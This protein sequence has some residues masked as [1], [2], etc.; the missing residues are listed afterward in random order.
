GAQEISRRV[1]GRVIGT[2]Q[3][4]DI[5]GE[6]RLGA[7]EALFNSGKSEIYRGVEQPDRAARRTRAAHRRREGIY[8]LFRAARGMKPNLS[9][10]AS[11]DRNIPPALDPPRARL[12]H[13]RLPIPALRDPY[14]GAGDLLRGPHSL[15]AR[16]ARPRLKPSR[17]SVRFR[18]AY[19]PS[20]I[21]LSRE[22]F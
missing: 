17:N 14:L 6:R 21:W 20:A 1:D 15:Q 13:P 9:R 5:T 19:R 3:G 8:V 10:L 18:L 4:D 22:E 16:G 11:D 7:R 2:D 12:R